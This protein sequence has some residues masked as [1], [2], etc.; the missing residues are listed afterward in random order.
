MFGYRI[1][2]IF[3]AIAVLLFLI[4]CSGNGNPVEPSDPWNLT[5][6]GESVGSNNQMLG[7]WHISLDPETMTAD[8]TPL[9]EA[10]FTFNVTRLLQPP[11]T[12]INM[13]TL[14]LEP[15]SDPANGLFVVDIN[16]RH[17]YS[18]MNIFNVFDMRGI[19]MSNG[20]VTG[21]HDLSVYRTGPGDTR[22]LNPDGYTRFWN[23]TEF[24]NYGTIFGFTGWNIAPPIGPSSTINPYKYFADGLSDVAPVESLDPATRGIFKAGG[25]NSRRYEIQFKMDGD[26]IV[27]D[28]NYSVDASWSA[29]NP[30]YAPDY[31][32]EAFDLSAN[33]QEPFFFKASDSGSTAYY[34]DD[35]NSGGNFKFDLEIFDRQA[36]MRPGGVPSE[37]STIWI[38]SD[39]LNAPV[40]VLSSAT[41][42]P[43]STVISSIFEIEL[44]NLNLTAN[45]PVGFLATVESSD[46][47]TYKPA[48]PNGDNFAYSPA[49]LAGYFTFDGNVSDVEPVTDWPTEPVLIDPDFHAAGTHFAIDYNGTIHA[50]YQDQFYVYWSTSTDK[51]FHWTNR[52]IIYSATSG[53]YMFR[54][55]FAMTSSNNYIYC[56]VTEWDESGGS[57]YTKLLTGRLDASDINSGW[58]FKMVWEHTTGST[59]DQN[60]SGLQIAVDNNGSMLIYAMLYNFASFI[61]K[62]AYVPDWDSLT[63][64]PEKNVSP[65]ENGFL[66]Y[67]YPQPTVELV[68]DSKG[69]FFM[70]FGGNFNDF[71]NENGSAND[72]GITMIRY[73]PAVDRWR[74]VQTIHHDLNTGLYWNSWANGLAIGSND[75]LYWVGGYQHD[76]CGFYGLQGGYFVLSYGTGMS[77][78]DH[79]FYYDDPINN[80]HNSYAECD[81]NYNY[82]GYDLMFVSSSIGVDPTTGGVVIVYQRSLTDCHV[83]AIRNDG[84]GWTDP[85]VQ[86]DGGL[87]GYNPYG[88]M[89]PSGWF[90]VTFTDTDYLGNGSKLPYFVAWK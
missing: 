32:P 30:A 43:G 4:G 35:S 66:T 47:T 64:T 18:G 28:F 83:R 58:E 29:P 26:N 51:G 42:S 36:N 82:Y 59:N 41:V 40:D 2:A 3:V 10:M 52:G 21:I 20:S 15:G 87:L 55:D 17:P 1:N 27:F 7:Y 53:N 14:T 31:P 6:Q 71:D 8:I 61:S 16:I 75:Q 13:I 34:V 67:Y 38:E 60:Y 9:R 65:L 69:N 78:G 37:I 39:A 89:H 45:G 62:Y 22:L 50:L 80:Y 11:A 74:F 25:I 49:H 77:T 57:P 73:T 88:R 33:V 84:S 81:L 23:P 46:P 44:S 68:A 90:L 63:G 19:F 86:I 70:V 76:N 12:M 24:T 72:Y 85:P 5:P 54:S 79:D 56:L 48:F